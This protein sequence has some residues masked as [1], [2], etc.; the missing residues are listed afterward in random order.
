[1]P[2]FKKK[3]LQIPSCAQLTSK[4]LSLPTW[5]YSRRK[6]SHNTKLH[7]MLELIYSY[8]SSYITT[9]HR[10]FSR[11]ISGARSSGKGDV[12]GPAGYYKFIM[13]IFSKQAVDHNA[14]AQR[15]A[16]PPTPRTE[17][18]LWYVGIPH[19]YHQANA[20]NSNI[21]QVFTTNSIYERHSFS[22]IIK[23]HHIKSS[24][25]TTYYID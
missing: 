9:I 25:S 19:D 23:L 16:L 10:Y 4:V 18:S 3:L 21:K 7:F 6:L 22:Q 8:A 15:D 13:H 1:M 14:L 5:F 2:Y 20:T 11:L 17:S 12:S 24:Y